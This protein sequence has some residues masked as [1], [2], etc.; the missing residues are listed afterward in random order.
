MEIKSFSVSGDHPIETIEWS[1]S[2]NSTEEKVVFFAYDAN[3]CPLPNFSEWKDE[4]F[5]EK[6]RE[7]ALQFMKGFKGEVWL[8]DV[9][10]KDKDL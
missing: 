10:I 7:K 6:Q 5:K 1:M 4:E 9:K 8:D 3:F 2:A